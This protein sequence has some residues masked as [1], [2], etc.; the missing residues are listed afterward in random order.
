[1]R[2]NRFNENSGSRLLVIS[3]IHGF[4]EGFRRLLQSAN[5][6]PSKDRLVLLGDYIE[7]GIPSTWK[8]LEVIREHQRLGAYVIAGNHELKLASRKNRGRLRLSKSRGYSAWISTLSLFLLADG[9]LFVHAG[10]RPGVPF[11]R[12]TVKDL[13]EIRQDFYLPPTGKFAK[14]LSVE[15][16][17]AKR[18]VFGH[19]PTFKLGAPPGTVWTDG[20]RIGIDTGA[21]HGLRL[22]LADLSNGIAYSCAAR[23]GFRCGDYKQAPLFTQ[24]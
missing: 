20:F 22:T 19:T 23:P 24:N 13:T 10:L 7:A 16:A 12:Q 9:Y 21:K 14:S 15:G 11:H 6:N 4:A 18:I 8:T 3:D 17:A 1:M 5:Y 2:A